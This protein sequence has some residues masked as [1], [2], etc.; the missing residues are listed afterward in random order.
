VDVV[1]VGAGFSGLAMGAKLKRAGR[2]NF[3]IVERAGD[4]G[5]VWRDNTYPGAA[6]DVPS[7]VYSL[8]FAHNPHWSRTYSHQPEI[9]RYLQRVARDED[10]LRHIRFHTEL[11]DAAWRDDEQ[12]G[13]WEIDTSTGPLRARAVVGA[14]GPLVEPRLPDVP[15]LVDFEGEVF[16]SARWNHDVDLTGKRVA[17]VGTGASAIQLIPEIAG[18]VGHMTV[19]QRT[20]PWVLPRTERPITRVERELFKRVPAAQDAV[21]KGVF[22]LRELGA[23]TPLL[24]PR[25]PSALAALGKAHIRRQIADPRLRAKVTPHYEPGCKRL[26]LSN[27]YYPAL[28]RPNVDVVPTGLTEVRGNTVVGADGSEAQVDVIIFGTGFEVTR[29]PVARHV[30][31]R[32]GI[33]LDE[34]WGGS[35]TAHRGTTV[36][37]FP[38]LFLLLGPNTGTGHMSVVFMAETQA[39]YVLDALGELDCRGDAALEP[40]T[41]AQDAWTD[42]VQ[43]RSQGTVWLG[44]GC[45]SWYLD[46]EGRN[47]TLWPDYAHRYAGELRRFDP[48]EHVFTPVRVPEV[49][50]AG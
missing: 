44:G 32:E 13:R 35:M 47:T 15:G 41:A 4:V 29:P 46:G 34:H 12:G 14:A 19:F 33:T 43:R 5:G 36:H 31:G 39:D 28:A 6:C 27:T 50:T 23:G 38:N 22:W 8:S 2:E 11:I 42:D 20:A 18:Q 25:K 26:L 45:A 24:H 10:L 17:V 49:V 16:H 9:H 21:R 30:R 40:T 1:I 3:V 37:G 7:H 48:A